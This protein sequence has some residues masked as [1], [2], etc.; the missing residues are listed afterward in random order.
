[1]KKQIMFCLGSSQ[2]HFSLLNMKL[3]DTFLNAIGRYLQAW[4]LKWFV[5]K[6][7]ISF[8]DKWIKTW[9]IRY[10]C[11]S[12]AEFFLARAVTPENLVQKAN[13]GNIF[14]KIVCLYKEMWKLF[15]YIIKR[16]SQFQAFKNKNNFKNM[17][18]SSARIQKLST[19][20]IK[21]CL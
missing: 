8:F 16:T 3:Y 19:T 21:R 14:W 13:F 1:M 2:K 10:Y 20:E 18:E 7:F 9:V 15:N 17:S 4:P 5:I 11:L 6:K 12:T